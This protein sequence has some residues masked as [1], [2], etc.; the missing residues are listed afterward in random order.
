MVSLPRIALSLLVSVAFAADKSADTQPQPLPAE[1]TVK[2]DAYI[3]AGLIPPH[4]AR[5]LF[6]KAVSNSF[7]VVQVIVSNRSNDAALMLHGL[8]IDDSRWLLGGC[9]PPSLKPNPAA[10]SN[11]NSN[12]APTPS[13][14][15]KQAP[16]PSGNEID[17]HQVESRACE[18]STVEVRAVRQIAQ[19]G[20]LSYWR[21][22]VLRYL[23]AIG[24]IGGGLTV[25]A[26]LGPV[27]PR[28]VSGYTTGGVT[29]FEFAFPDKT[30]NQ[31]NLINDTA[32]AVNT[33]V[34]KQSSVMVFAFFPIER[35]LGSFLMKYF[36]KD[37]ALFFSPASFLMDPNYQDFFKDVLD[38]YADDDTQK[39]GLNLE[40]N[41]GL[42]KL[43]KGLTLNNMRVIAQGVY[44]VNVE[45]VAADPSGLSFDGKDED[46]F[47][48]AGDV[49]GT[50]NGRLLTGGVPVLQ[51]S[52]KLGIT[53]ARVDDGSTETALKIKLTLKKPVP[54]QTLTF[55]V[56]KS[57]AGA[58]DLV[59][60]PVTYTIE[61]HPFQGA[62]TVSNGPITAKVGGSIDL[63]GAKIYDSTDSAKRLNA[64]VRKK[65]SADIS[66]PDSNLTWVSPTTATITLPD[67]VAAGSYQIILRSGTAESKPVDLTVQ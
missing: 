60:K 37:T 7:A 43:L 40:K 63:T 17:S 55:T 67:A 62:P 13:G 5:N 27:L 59:S 45:D 23:K 35:F 51:D 21:N 53:A 12:P 65:G 48:K 47:T 8:S 22:Q 46:I 15:T 4:V 39:A 49:T 66:I 26:G 3:T 56:K 50:I 32:F 20:Q 57:K 24:D 6:G 44:V 30:I 33:V 29:A 61:Y 58:A 11:G 28:A 42:A 10:A 25:A 36:I 14:Q 41:K 31:I 1:I 52:D 38:H 64:I 54:E 19:N 9:A 18:V 16:T 34:P 2:G